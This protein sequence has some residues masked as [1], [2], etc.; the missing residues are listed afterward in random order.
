MPGT[1]GSEAMSSSNV[2]LLAIFAL[3]YA[4]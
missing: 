2:F 1:N 3:C 4:Y